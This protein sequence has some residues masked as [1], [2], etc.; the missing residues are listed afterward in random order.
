MKFLKYIALPAIALSLFASCD[1]L[2]DDAPDD[3]LSEEVIWSDPLVVDEYMR[4]L[5]RG[6]DSGFNTLVTTIMKGLGTEYEL[7]FGDQLTVGKREWYSTDYGD[8][9]KS[10]QSQITIRSRQKWSSCYSHIRSINLLL[11]NQ[12]RLPASI[13]DRVIGE[14]HFFRAYYYY[15]LLI[16]FGGPLIITNTLRPSDQSGQVPSRKL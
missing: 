13:R 15:K 16:N 5:Y 11:E 6:M 9:L 1:D 7:W 14:A 3:K 4:G 12:H 8:L 10:V 2:F